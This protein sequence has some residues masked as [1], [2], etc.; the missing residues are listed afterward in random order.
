MKLLSSTR[1]KTILLLLI[2]LVMFAGWQVGGETMYAKVLVGTTNVVL[3]AA[4]N[5]SHIEYKKE[6]SGRYHFEV[7]TRI[8]GRKAH[9]PQE[10]G[11]L[12]QPFVIVLSWQI[13]LFF[14]LKRR[15]AIQSLLVNV[16]VFLLI[17]IIFMIMLT[18]YYSSDFMQY[19]FTMMMDSFYIIALVLVIKDQM[20]YQVFAKEGGAK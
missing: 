1:N 6:G 19:V 14:V 8:D 10:T 5:D 16:A 11:G 17:Q 20:L 13:F 15:S 4:T 7:H 2:T 3:D 18:G 9:Y 12:M